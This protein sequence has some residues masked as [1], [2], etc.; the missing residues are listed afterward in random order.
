M[1]ESNI[2][3][4]ECCGSVCTCSS[5]T[6]TR[7]WSTATMPGLW[8]VIRG[9]GSNIGVSDGL[10]RPCC[11][12]PTPGFPGATNG[13]EE[14]LACTGLDGCNCSSCTATW[15]TV[16]DDW[17]LSFCAASGASN[18]CTCPTQ[19][20]PTPRPSNGYVI[21]NITCSC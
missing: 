21:S 12:C 20:K 3:P 17:I 9:C 15:S 2:G 18:R 6:C 13:Q 16:L 1:P 8:N 7:K 10:D 4:C 5:V 11:G 19:A 14:T